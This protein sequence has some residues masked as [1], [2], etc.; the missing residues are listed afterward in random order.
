VYNYLK[1]NYKY[2]Y[3]LFVIDIKPNYYRFEAYKYLSALNPSGKY[4][5][6]GTNVFSETIFACNNFVDYITLK[7]SDVDLE[8]IATKASGSAIGWPTN[9]ERQLIRYQ[10]LEIFVRLALAKFHK[11]NTHYQSISI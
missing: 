6:I 4:W 2:M 5:S 10:F 8:F 1:E 9:P 11:S 7:H 3:G